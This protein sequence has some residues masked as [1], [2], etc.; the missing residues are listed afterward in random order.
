M[1][2]VGGVDMV[3]NGAIN[4]QVMFQCIVMG[5]RWSNGEEMPVTQGDRKHLRG[6]QLTWA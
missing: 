6:N 3:V 1:K 5:K 2:A 4:R